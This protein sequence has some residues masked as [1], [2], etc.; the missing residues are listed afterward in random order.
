[1]A[2]NI[3]LNKK[4]NVVSRETFTNKVMSDPALKQKLLDKGLINERISEFEGI[5]NTH[6]IAKKGTSWNDLYELNEIVVNAIKAANPSMSGV[7][8]TDFSFNRSRDSSLSNAYAFKS[9]GEKLEPVIEMKI[10]PNPEISRR[11]NEDSKHFKFNLT[12]PDLNVTVA[13]AITIENMSE[14]TWD[15]YSKVEKVLTDFCNRS[16]TIV[17]KSQA[18]NENSKYLHLV[19]TSGN[20]SFDV[21]HLFSIDMDWNNDLGGI[22]VLSFHFTRAEEKNKETIV[23][24]NPNISV[25]KDPLLK[26]N[27]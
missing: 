21:G 6:P 9:K 3:R 24:T 13:E 4:L 16:S 25:D 17:V 20:G 5:D 19:Y 18:E 26:N 27:G 7:D 12:A 15:D 23:L 1:M 22:P 8:F 11:Y 14:L 2:F 10:S